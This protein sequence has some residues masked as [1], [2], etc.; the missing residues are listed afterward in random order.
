[1]SDRAQ[2]ALKATEIAIG[3]LRTIQALTRVGPD[4]A[5]DAL[6]TIN[7]IVDVLQEGLDGRTSPEVVEAELQALVGDL[8]LET[9]TR[10]IDDKFDAGDES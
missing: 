5:Q 10:D 9:A 2:D 6:L 3:T 4:K 8:D 1:M 7:A